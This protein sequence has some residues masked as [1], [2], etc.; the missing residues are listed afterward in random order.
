MSNQ[1]AP[2]IELLRAAYAAFNARDIDAALALMTPDVAWPKAFKGG[3]VRGVEEVRAYWTE[4]WS[5]INPHVEPISFYLEE[6]GHILVDVHQVVRD[7]G[8]AVLA[9]EHVGHRFTL[10]QGLIQGMEVC[11]LPSSTPKT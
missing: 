8:G 11:S 9:D 1:P 4:Q 5:E 6:A 2:E 10:E 3:F 7:L